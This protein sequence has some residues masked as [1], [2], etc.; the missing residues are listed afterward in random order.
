MDVKHT[1]PALG[2]C[3]RIKKDGEIIAVLPTLEAASLFIEVFSHTLPR[4]CPP[5]TKWELEKAYIPGIGF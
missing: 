1:G 5:D 4:T 2:N 3:Y